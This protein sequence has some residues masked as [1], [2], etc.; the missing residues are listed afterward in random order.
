MLDCKGGLVL[1][2]NVEQQAGNDRFRQ[3]LTQSIWSERV[4]IMLKVGLCLS[5]ILI[6]VKHCGVR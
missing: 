2:T 6:A 3:K 4:L 5:F 1:C